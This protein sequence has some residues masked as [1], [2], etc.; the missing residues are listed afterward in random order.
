V[1]H[2][3]LTHL[4]YDH[5]GLTPAFGAARLH[6][7]SAELE[8][9]SGPFADRSSFGDIYSRDDIGFIKR[10]DDEGRVHRCDADEEIVPGISVHRV[11]GHTPG[12]QVVR[13]AT[14]AGPLVLAS[15]SSHYYE[16]FMADRPYSLVHNVADMH[17][18]FNRL[19]ELTPHAELIVP[20]HDPA[21]LERFPDRASCDRTRIILLG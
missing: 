10:A 19:R 3:V 21:V 17:A 13:V 8:F 2:V 5:S 20:G 11:G 12:M 15:D 18:A 7:Q 4:H 1:P 14:S 9:W 6:V 16:N